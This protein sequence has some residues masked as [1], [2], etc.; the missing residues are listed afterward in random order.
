MTKVDLKPVFQTLFVV[1]IIVAVGALILSLSIDRIVKSNIEASLT[2][3]LQTAVEVENVS[4][5]MLDGSGTIKGIILHNPE[6]FSNKPAVSLQ[7]I[8]LKMNVPSLLADTVIINE[9]LIRQ[10]E[11]YFE[12]RASGNNFDA[13]TE[14]MRNSSSSGSSV[15]VEYLL[16]E[17]GQVTLTADMGEEQSVEAMFSRIELKGIG[18]KGNNSLEQAL[19][20][21]LEPILKKALR[22]TATEGLLDQAKEALQDIFEG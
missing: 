2:E 3:L 15:I 21:I 22:E 11:L 18:R 5:S 16:V 19:R 1:V 13:L 8:S 4:I 14:K 17:E 7:K 6:G 9:I 10:P 12:Q 20:Q